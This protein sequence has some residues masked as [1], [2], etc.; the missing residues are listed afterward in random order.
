MS[1]YILLATYNGNAF[2]SEQ[3][4]S[5]LSQADGWELLVRDDDSS[6]GT[7]NLIHNRVAK[8]APIIFIN[9]GKSQLGA[10]GNFARLLE[11]AGQK[12]AEYCTLSDQD[13]LWLPSKLTKQL[14]QMKFLE[15]KFPHCPILLHTDLE[16]VNRNLESIHPSFMH[17]QGIRHEESN[18]L[19][20]LLCQ[21]FVTGSTA[22]INRA[23][24]DMALPIPE[25]ALMHDW[26]L[27]LCAAVFGRLEYNPQPTVKYRQHEHNVI[28]AKRIRRLM[29]PLKNNWLS[30]WAGGCVNLAGSILQARALAERIRKHDPQNPHLHLVE[31]YASLMELPPF[32]RI[33]A[34]KKSGIHMQSS[35]RY[36]LM[37]SRLPFIH[38][39]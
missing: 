32:K 30:H 14:K 35:L 13:D 26:W 21:N 11:I 10:R 29:N 37:I 17:Y 3:L 34:I 12:G 28:G 25:A 27:A 6:D 18:P 16:V 15:Q 38:S 20:V 4:E 8:G 19:N 1:K 9:D 36:M 22:I 24:L 31:G 33:K 39:G 2:L 23:L 5:I 7:Q